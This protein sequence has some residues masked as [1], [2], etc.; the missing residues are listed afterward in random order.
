MYNVHVRVA[1]RENPD[2][3]STIDTTTASCGQAGFHSDE[4]LD[5]RINGYSSKLAST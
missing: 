4:A 3:H 1:T 5:I 2:T